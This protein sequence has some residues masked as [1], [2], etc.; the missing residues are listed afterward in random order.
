MLLLSISELGG[1]E[2]EGGI[3]EC[4]PGCGKTTE[5]IICKWKSLFKYLTGFIKPRNLSAG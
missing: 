3:T 5:K 2:G 4:N 1:R